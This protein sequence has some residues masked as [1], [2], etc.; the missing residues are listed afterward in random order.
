MHDVWRSEMII[1]GAKS[2]I[3]MTG[4]KIVEMM[5]DVHGR[6]LEERKVQKILNGPIPKS[7]KDARAFIDVCV[8]YRIFIISF[9]TIAAP[10]F[11]LFRRGN[12]FS[13]LMNVGLQWKG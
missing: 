4:I 7:T 9:S 13:G 6:R 1:S 11:N 5:C 10:I 8:Y 3:G 2:M 12:D